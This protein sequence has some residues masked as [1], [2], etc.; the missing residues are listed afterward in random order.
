MKIILKSSVCDKVKRYVSRNIK[1][2]SDKILKLW[3]IQ[4]ES[5]LAQRFRRGQQMIALYSRIW[6]E[7]ALKEMLIRFNKLVSKISNHMIIK[8]NFIYLFLVT[9]KCKNYAYEFSWIIF[10]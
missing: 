5:I 8:I 1:E 10:I 6:D 3:S 9:K 4:C 7:K 2:R